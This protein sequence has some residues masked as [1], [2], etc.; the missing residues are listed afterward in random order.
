MGELLAASGLASDI[1]YEILPQ[2]DG[3]LW[4]AT[5]GG[6]LRGTRQQFGI[7]WKNV[8]A[9]LVS[10]CTVFKWLPT[11][12]YGPATETRGIARIHTPTGSVQWFGQEQGLLGSAAYT[13]RF[14]REKRLWAATEVGLF[15]GNRSVPEVLANH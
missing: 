11:G 7:T 9:W 8:R 4:V 10:R 5:E 14:D 15:Y 3:S 13:L 6:L 2:P 1:V 12:I